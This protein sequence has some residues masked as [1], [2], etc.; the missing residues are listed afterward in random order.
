M[1]TKALFESFDEFIMNEIV[2]P[3]ELNQIEKAADSYFNRIGLDIEFTR[4]FLD[5]VNDPRNKRQITTQELMDIFKDAYNRYGLKLRDKDIDYEAVFKDMTSDIN[6]PFVL[7]YNR[8][9]GDTELIMKTIMRKKGF[10]T[11]NDIYKLTT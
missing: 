1:K 3:Q 7:S 5:R 11:P 6:S 2:T 4:H 10:K 9:S 8:R